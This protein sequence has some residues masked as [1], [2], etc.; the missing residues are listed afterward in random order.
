MGNDMKI[1]QTLFSKE[2]EFTPDELE[3]LRTSTS[4]AMSFGMLAW[5]KETFGLNMLPKKKK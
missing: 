2:I 4:P 1:K 3:R 5:I